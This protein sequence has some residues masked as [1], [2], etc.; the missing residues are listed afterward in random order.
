M[1]ELL[2]HLLAEDLLGYVHI[3]NLF[4]RQLAQSLQHL[5]GSLAELRGNVQ[6][7]KCEGLVVAAL[8]LHR[9]RLDESVV[10]G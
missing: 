7:V 2:S 1:R 6:K 8:R 4:C 10:D 5:S 3:Q 9:N